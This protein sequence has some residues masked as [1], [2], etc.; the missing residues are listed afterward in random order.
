MTNRPRLLVSVKNLKEAEAAVAGGVDWIDLK[1]PNRG[2]L[3]PVDVGKAIDVAER[4]ADH[5][6]VSAAGG[7]LLDW[8]TEHSGK[9]LVEVP[10]I[11]LIKLGLAGCAP[12]LDWGKKWLAV[13]EDIRA[14]GKK[15]AAVVY[16]DWTT[17]SAPRPEQIID[18]AATSTCE[19]L[20]FDTFDKSQGNLCD[21]LSMEKL[22]IGRAHV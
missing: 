5:F 3:G 12:L 15:I 2:A 1:Q 17:A 22:Q 19:T 18:L 8:Y 14:A 9:L 20:L 13:Q 21:H 16:A 11:C 6:P 7:E 10:G 4:F